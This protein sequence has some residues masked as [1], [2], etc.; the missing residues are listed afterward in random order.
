MLFGGKNEI[1]KNINKFTCCCN[2]IYGCEFRWDSS[3]RP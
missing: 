1:P 3:S 2:K